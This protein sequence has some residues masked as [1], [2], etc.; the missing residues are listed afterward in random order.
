ML[1]R[2]LFDVATQRTIRQISQV[3]I[4]PASDI[5]LTDAQLDEVEKQLRSTLSRQEKKLDELTRDTLRETLEQD[6]GALRAHLGEARLYP[7]L[8][9][10]KDHHSI[11]DYCSDAPIILSSEEEVKDAV[12][13][14]Q[15][16]TIIYIQ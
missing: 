5:L 13:R 12:K 11:S 8:A 15:E 7:Y 14:I 2:S 1:F 6:M 16:E 9:W 4:I 10:L 3:R